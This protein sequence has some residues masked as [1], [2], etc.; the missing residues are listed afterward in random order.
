ML[1]IG[2]I[3]DTHGFFDP[4][5]KKHF[6]E[7]DEIW[8]AGDIGEMVVLEKLQSMKPVEVVHGNIETP[9]IQRSLPEVIVA[10]KEGLKLMMIHIA[11]RPGR[12]AKGIDSLLKKHQ[13]DLL[14][15]GHSH[16]L[17]VERDPRYNMIYLN[18]GA[19]GQQGF[20]KKRT[21]LLFTID[22]GKLKDMKAVELG[23]RGK[24]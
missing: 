18:P 4:K 21:I 17:R 22:S 11:G 1:K 20:H 13:P 19:A 14:I 24:A 2:L 15:C 7:V 10:S 5:L 8:H 12:Y 16:I 9:Q 3:A 23:V 6:E